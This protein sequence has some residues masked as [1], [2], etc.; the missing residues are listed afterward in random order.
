MNRKES[1]RLKD[2]LME[3]SKDFWTGDYGEFDLKAWRRYLKKI[4]VRMIE[5]DDL[6]VAYNNQSH[7]TV[8]VENPHMGLAWMVMPKELALK[9]LV[10]GQM[11]PRYSKKQAKKG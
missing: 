2:L 3:R 6:C 4:N 7:D 5:D 9:C 11:P 1:D 10:L 8:L